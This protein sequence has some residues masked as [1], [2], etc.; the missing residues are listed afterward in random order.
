M[1]GAKNDSFMK[2]FLPGLV[3]GIVIGAVAGATLPTLLS[4]PSPGSVKGTGT[5][6]HR[7]MDD[8]ES[9]T[10]VGPQTGDAPVDP[11]QPTGDQP[12]G[13][14]PTGEQP[15]GEHPMGDQPA[16]PPTG[17][18]PADPPGRSA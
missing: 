3:L 9:R 6:D 15:T 14:T 16:T 2:A 8:R 18:T 13:E 5:T 4:R 1:S 10:P 11:T 17:D 12:A 7:R